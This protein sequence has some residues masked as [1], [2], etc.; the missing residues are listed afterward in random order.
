M[1]LRTQLI[2]KVSTTLL[3]ILLISLLPHQ[4]LAARQRQV[5]T[6]TSVVQ[7]EPLSMPLADAGFLTNGSF[8]TQGTVQAD[9]AEWSEAP[10]HLRANDRARDGNW[11]LRS[12]S[13][14]AAAATTIGPISVTPNTDYALTGY[15]YKAATTGQAYIDMND[16]ANELQL[17]ST[18]DNSWQYL[19]GIWN[20]GSRT[21]VTI[22]LVTQ[23]NP[24]GSIWFDK[25]IF[26]V[27]RQNLNNTSFETA[28]ATTGDALKW[29][30][31][32]E[33]TRNNTRAHDGS[34]SI[35]G[36][37]NPPAPGVSTDSD[38]VIVTPHTNYRLSGWIYRAATQGQATIDMDDIPGELELYS[39]N[40]ANAWQYV[41][42]VWDSGT[43]TSVIIR[44]VTHD[45]INGNVWFDEVSFEVEPDPT[46]TPT[47]TA[48]PI[49]PPSSTPT[50]TRTATNTATNTPTPT[51][52]STA[53]NTPTPTP[54]LVGELILNPVSAGPNTLGLT[55]TLVAVLRD[56]T[57]APLPNVT[58]QFT[59][60]G[61]N[62]HVATRVT[63]QHGEATYEYLGAN[64]GIDMVVATIASPGVAAATS[65]TAKVRWANL[66]TASLALSPANAGLKIVGTSQEFEATLTTVPQV[67]GVTIEF[68][69]RDATNAVVT[70]GL[71]RTDLAGKAT[72]SYSGAAPGLH[73][74]QAVARV[75][76]QQTSSNSASVE[77][78][79]LGDNALT[80]APETA[81]P[82][83]TGTQ[84]TVVATLKNAA[85]T[86]IAGVTIEFEMSGPN[87]PA[88]IGTAT[89]QTD[90]TASYTYQGT[91]AGTDRIQAKTT[92]GT[93]LLASNVSTVTWV[94]LAAATLTLIPA[95]AGPNPTGANQV[96]EAQLVDTSGAPIPDI[97][98]QFA[99]QPGSVNTASGNATTDANGRATFSFIGITAGTDIVQATANLGTTQQASN[100]ASVT[101]QVPVKNVTMSPVRGRFF[102]NANHSGVFETTPGM[103]P[104]F[105][106]TFSTLNFNPPTGGSWNT[107]IKNR[108]LTGPTAVT[109]NTVQ[110]WNLVTDVDNNYIDRVMV[111]GNG[112]FAGAGSGS[113]PVPPS[114][115]SFDAVFTGEF[116]VQTAGSVT[117]RIAH[118]DGY[119]LGIGNGATRVTGLISP[120]TLSQT[121]FE[122]YPVMGAY[123]GTIGVTT[124]D[125]VV[126]FPAPG[127]YPYEI[128][129][130]QGPASQ[131]S[132]TVAMM[133]NTTPESMT[134][135]TSLRLSPT[136]VAAT[137][138]G[139]QLSFTVEMKNS[140]N[141]G[142]RDQLITLSVTGANPQ[143]LT[144]FTNG[145]GIATFQLRGYNVGADTL[146][147][148]A[149][150]K[151]TPAYSNEVSV[152]WTA[153]TPPSDPYP[154]NVPG[155]IGAPI[156]QSI[157]SG[158]IPIQLRA[159]TT[160]QPG[161]TVDYW[162]SP[163]PGE[164][165]PAVTTPADPARDASEIAALDT[166]RLANGSYVIRVQGTDSAGKQVACGV[167]VT[168]AGEFKPGRVAF[169]VTDLVVPLLGMPIEIGR[170]YDSL[171]RNQVGDFGYGWSLTVGNPNLKVDA[172]HNVTFDLPNGK[173]ASFFFTPEPSEGLFGYLMYPAYTPEAGVYGTL[174]SDGCGIVVQS[175]SRYLCF[176]DAP[177]YA[178]TTYTYTNPSGWQY[179]MGADGSLKSIKD[180]QGNQLNFTANGVTVTTDGRTVDGRSVTFVRDT[181]NSNPLYRNRITA[182]QVKNDAGTVISE[183]TY[184][185]SPEADLQ[186]VTLPNPKPE[187]P[188]SEQPVI[189]YEY[190]TSLVGAEWWGHLFKKATDPLNHPQVLQT[191]YTAPAE[192]QGRI[193]STTEYVDGDDPSTPAV[194]PLKTHTTGYDYDLTLTQPIITITNPDGGRE[195][196]EYI[197]KT[198]TAFGTTQQSDMLPTRET[199][200]VR[201][202]NGV[203]KQRTTSYDYDTKFNLSRI[204]LPDPATGA[205]CL[206]ATDPVACPNQRNISYTYT[207]KGNTETETDA[208][209]HTT[210]NHFANKTV[211]KITV[212]VVE[213]QKD[214][215]NNYK[216]Y[217]YDEYLN[218]TG[219][220]LS[221]DATKA[222]NERIG[223][224]TYDLHGNIQTQYLGS[225]PYNAT[226]SG[227]D[228]R[229]NL[230][231][232]TDLSGNVTQYQNYDDFGRVGTVSVSGGNGTPNET[233]YV[234]DDLGQVE[235]VT[236]M[237]DGKTR[238]TSYQYDL[239]GRQTLQQDQ[240]T[241]LTTC[242]TYYYN[243]AVKRATLDE[244]PAPA[245]CAGTY[246]DSTYTWRG[247]PAT[248]INQGGH[249]T[250][251]TYDYTGA[252]TS[253]TE[254]ANSTTEAATTRY[255]YD[256]A[257]RPTKEIDAN[258]HELTSTFDQG[259]RVD[260]S[261]EIVNGVLQTTNYVY[262][263]TLAGDGRL[264]STISLDGTPAE[265]ETHYTYDDRGFATDVAYANG[266]PD[267]QIEHREHDGMGNVTLSRDRA[268]KTTTYTY[269]EAK[270]ITSV[271][272][273]L[274]HKTSYT[275][276]Q[277]GY[278]A[279]IIDPN[280]HV[281]SF[282]YDAQGRTIKKIWPDLSEERYV[283]DQFES[284]PNNAALQNERVTSI[285][286]D[287]KQNNYISDYQGRL[288]K[289]IPFTG[290]TVAY[291]YNSQGL[292]EEL[293]DAQGLSCYDY[294][295]RE[296]I[297]T[298]KYMGTTQ[299]TCA[300]ATV[301]KSLGYT[302]D[303]VGAKLSMTTFANSRTT[304]TNYGYDELGRLCKV[305]VGAAVSACATSQSGAYTYQ[306]NDAARTITLSYPNGVQSVNVFDRLQRLTSITQQLN[307][308]T[309]GSYS[310]SY[311]PEYGN[312]RWKV[313]EG[314]QSVTEWAYDDASRVQS[315]VHTPGT[316][317][318]VGWN[319]QYTYDP[320]GHI[321]NRATMVENGATTQYFYKANG[322]DQV[323][324]IESSEGTIQHQYDGRGNLLRE[325]T[326][327]YTFDVL[328]RVSKIYETQ[329][330][331]TY[332][333][334]YTYDAL[335]HRIA[336]T[337]NGVGTEYLWDPSTDYRDVVVETTGNQETQ[338]VV[339]TFGVLGQ[340]QTN[341][342]TQSALVRYLLPDGLGS[343]RAL[344]DG[345]GATLETYLY[346]AFGQ[347]KSGPAAPGTSYLYTGQQYDSKT[348]LYNLRARTYNPSTGRFLSRDTFYKDLKASDELNRYGYVANNPIN[349][350]DPTG[351]MA[352]S[353]MM[354]KESRARARDHAR[355]TRGVAPC[356]GPDCEALILDGIFSFFFDEVVAQTMKFLFADVP[357]IL[358]GYR[359]SGRGKELLDDLVF[360]LGTIKHLQFQGPGTITKVLSL[361]NKEGT[362]WD[363][364]ANALGTFGTRGGGRLANSISNFLGGWGIDIHIIMGSQM[365]GPAG[366]EPM[367]VG[368]ERAQCAE[369]IIARWAYD[370]YGG[371]PTPHRVLDIASS[372]EPCSI[373]RFGL[374]SCEFYLAGLRLAQPLLFERTF[375]AL[376]VTIR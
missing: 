257:G 200:D 185:Y 336:Q 22:R 122:Q 8:E 221:D 323:D 4:A 138:V 337:A 51:P 243:G 256:L 300:T 199:V 237:A 272:N 18:A 80:L 193:E 10:L 234:Y 298:I 33:H 365:G 149:W 29:T 49:T 113:D 73:T 228:T 109:P 50:L 182:V 335:W 180:L 27:A 128:D 176:L 312:N 288:I 110:F 285:L 218:S 156:N 111:Q 198:V 154:L 367:L 94:D 20:S 255:D 192:K 261:Q 316:V 48:T 190:Y 267:V 150:Y 205:V 274:G 217:G 38:P 211:G 90:G 136:T 276:T 338:Y 353:S 259:D 171:N 124:R 162:L 118:D 360:G 238:T 227:Y 155:C 55:Q 248:V 104:V 283:Y 19:H 96:L 229:G 59:L 9:A 357:I 68:T 92:I 299:G 295:E 354:S 46:A 313:T 265:T 76:T 32:T 362:K 144:A 178:P 291:T 135:Y 301:Q 60:T 224:Y 64:P 41:T 275:Y 328:D 317:N 179:K 284:D 166:T 146:K 12:T 268:L 215:W 321:G 247:D 273:P 126:N 366:Q 87:T 121:V 209:G 177:E 65:N 303:D 17:W 172:A 325:G 108:P 258:N 356:R 91:L 307:G 226:S 370:E 210:T 372:W 260:Y 54:T 143:E 242:S 302:Y 170:S 114:M 249:E 133:N 361:N 37:A 34:W 84:H 161:Y 175:G 319:V 58:I 342:Q 163:K 293:R 167:L 213:W 235:T 369:K 208:L 326:A 97:T 61:A 134:S 89:T 5:D 153:G 125:V 253:V 95:Q 278:L 187:D 1:N 286:A 26:A 66:G 331:N 21:S 220:Y 99:T 343:T 101:W 40:T 127:R 195:I 63:D 159:G 348:R 246:V 152:T 359:I 169:S 304:T 142:M 376:N 188:T 160:L 373:E 102:F 306:Y 262:D 85:G 3:L 6:T 310:Y 320:V 308:T 196:T 266:T 157:V 86:G 201:V 173:R 71:A 241:G 77:W 351:N 100:T 374:D 137:P 184:G 318:G 202:E 186:S 340:T 279:S 81:G 69:V 282:E 42:G 368:G 289:E 206:P 277:E 15:I 223:G 311:K 375:T 148:S 216:L 145:S 194:E 151:G 72:F 56:D 130:T 281:T 120:A 28:G 305:K 115:F 364:Y 236:N 239:S 158:I 332:R 123:N 105:E 2:R 174:T 309:I 324:H 39:N 79:A 31:A 231:T 296:W 350:I 346:D 254:A 334:N 222:E 245:S 164:A 47:N 44:L 75:G 82:L 339:G 83:T 297:K 345:S 131:R 132:L 333:R 232:Q 93:S 23:N 62:G 240:T 183:Y 25:L 117:F 35:K 168:V 294:N 207:A 270:R 181:L 292:L 147:A 70:T 107:L 165:P 251:F 230:T 344:L 352:E 140:A 330:G 363:R 358:S 371:I 263:D 290:Q 244:N 191:Y 189:T 36:T 88:T 314:D 16:I 341:L 129:Y 197:K 74:V 287:G 119:I 7:R 322:L 141:A 212:E 225:N 280:N 347:L 252:K 78:I 52:T 24:N 214:N 139:Q 329:G 13:T 264:A 103:T 98:V 45:S 14:A 250:S 315:E 233:T 116:V 53:T 112:Y 269:D 43:K 271:T 327:Y 11:S 67:D 349:A 30:E 204:S 106:Q 355:Y 203:T 219:A 57:G